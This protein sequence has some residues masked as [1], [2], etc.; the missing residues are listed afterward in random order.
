M[1]GILGLNLMRNKMGYCDGV[2]SVYGIN[3]DTC[4]N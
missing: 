1:F 2:T 3:R 4:V